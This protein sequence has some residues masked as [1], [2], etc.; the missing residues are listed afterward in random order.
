MDNSYLTVKEFAE[1]ANISQQ[2][3]YKQINGRLKPFIHM[4]RGQKVIEAAAL[5]NS[6]QPKFNN[7]STQIQPQKFKILNRRMNN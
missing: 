7:H 3:V 2:A 6:I 4:V 1:K 5:K